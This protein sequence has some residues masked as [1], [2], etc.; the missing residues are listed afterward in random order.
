MSVTDRQ[1]EPAAL[2]T[3][4]ASNGTDR[5]TGWQLVDGPAVG[6]E[7]ARAARAVAEARFHELLE[8]VAG[9]ALIIDADGSVAFANEH[10]AALLEWPRD[11][12]V[13]RD[14][15]EACRPG[16]DRAD[17]RAWLADVVAGHD[18]TE[19]RHEN[20]V[21][22]RSGGMRTISWSSTVLRDV[23]GAVSSIASIGEDVTDARATEAELARLVA[24]VEQASDMIAITSADG[25]IEYVNR[26]F[27][28]ESGYEADFAIGEK[29]VDLVRSGSHPEAF[30]TEL[31][32][33]TRREGAWADTI[34]DRRRDGS[35]HEVNLRISPIRGA[36]GEIA[37]FVHV[38]RDLT[39]E[40]ALEGQLRQAVKMEAI[41]QLAGG[42]AHD[43]NNMLTAIRGYAE[44]VD[45]EISPENV[46]LRDDL[47]QI[48][49]TADRAAALTRQ[50]L[51]FA[52]KQVV[53][54]TILDPSEVVHGLA[55]M[56]RRLLGEHVELAIDARRDGGRILIDPHQLEQVIVNLAV[57]GRDAM[58]GGGHLTVT[59]RAVELDPSSQRAWPD[60][61]PGPHVELAVADTG[62]GMTREIRDRVFEPFFTTKPPGHGTGMGLAMVH[63]IVTG[64]GGAIGIESAPGTGSTFRLRFPRRDTPAGLDAQDD[65]GATAPAGRGTVL[66]VEDEPV[67]RAFA[68]RCLRQ[69]GY[70]VLEAAGGDEALD[71]VA[72]PGTDVDLLVTDVSMPGMPGTELAHR[73]QAAHPR[74]PVLFVSGYADSTLVGEGWMDDAS[75]FLPKPYTRESLGRAVAEALADTRD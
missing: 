52:R 72:R 2:R 51:A 49:L 7:T 35:L 60:L 67:V 5:P 42:V 44:L 15:F 71:L 9:C 33:A 36:T 68:S 55:P 1:R 53:E 70:A 19:A 14:W 46:Q 62:T 63:G 41:G 30:Y 24:A 20:N 74:L 43:F 25:T 29:L 65:A 34:V 32:D 10:L 31:D 48:I 59:L 39:R 26:A 61:A 47:S 28:V 73:I 57:N 18:V 37:G 23:D 8:S 66:L 64:A 69:L 11:E 54:P 22:T 13:G 16:A 56:L 75:G 45:G 17:A 6:I 27:E 21:Q 58:P 3:T 40:R 38:G 4:P 12:L 50:L